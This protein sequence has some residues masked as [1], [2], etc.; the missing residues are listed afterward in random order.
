[1]IANH[2]LLTDNVHYH[3]GVDLTKGAEIYGKFVAREIYRKY[4]D[5]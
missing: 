3:A 4:F 1:M 5:F 2:K